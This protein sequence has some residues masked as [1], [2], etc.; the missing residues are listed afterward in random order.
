MYYGEKVK[1]AA[2]KEIADENITSHGLMF[3]KRREVTMKKYEAEPAEVKAKVMKEHKK[4]MKNL[5]KAR[6]Q[7]K[8]GVKKPVDNSTKTKYAHIFICLKTAIHKCAM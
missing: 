1:H 4:A 6:K 3:Q 5:Q 7:A 8:S 2:D